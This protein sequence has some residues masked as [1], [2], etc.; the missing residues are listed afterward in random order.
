L[1][2]SVLPIALG[3]ILAAQHVQNRRRNEIKR[4]NQ[5]EGTEIP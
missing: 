4:E 3:D 2:R 1:E 5:D